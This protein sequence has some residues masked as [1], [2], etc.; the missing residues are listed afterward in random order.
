MNEIKMDPQKVSAILD[1]P[2]PTNKKGVQHFVGLQTF[3]EDLSRDFLPLL[4]PITQL[5]KQSINFHWTP[6]TKTA[7]E[8]LKGFFT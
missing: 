2:A 1:W 4:P 5:T 8:T 7:L 3:T 6:E